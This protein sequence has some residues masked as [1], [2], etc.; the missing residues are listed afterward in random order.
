LD[1]QPVE[2]GMSMIAEPQRKFRFIDLVN[3]FDTVPGP[4]NFVLPG[5]LQGTIGGLVSA[6][7]VGKSTLTL[8]AACA[9]AVDVAGADLL[10]LNLSSHGP[11]VILAGE[12]PDDALHHRLH[13]LGRHLSPAQRAALA[14]RL[15]I[16]PCMGL[17]V[18]LGNQDWFEVIEE[19]A[20]DARLLVIDTLTRFHSL[21]ENNASDAKKIM[22]CM[23]GIAARTGCSILYLH[24]INKS[25]AVGGMA[26]L[27]QAARGSSVFV[28][29]ARWLAFV[30]G[31]TKDEA[32]L[33]G[34]DQDDRG[35]YVRWGVSKQNYAA[36]MPDK[37]L[38]RLDGGVLRAIELR[39][40][41][42][43]QTKKK[44][45]NYD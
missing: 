4:L 36:P 26:D 31:M 10:E 3:C 12:D 32:E 5:F 20:Q 11:V 27:Q 2:V 38:R 22:A 29:N 9:V 43:Q 16:A 33:H 28:D 41:E 15:H 30:A 1:Q 19:Q 24:H 6:G 25:A 45:R 39:A 18:D 8:L 42:P 37:W 13:A 44:W 7:G 14:E 34:I 17:G 21:D 35:L 23:E 40:V